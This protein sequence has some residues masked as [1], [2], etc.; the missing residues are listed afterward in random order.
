MTPEERL[1]FDKMKEDIIRLSNFQ[2]EADKN[3]LFDGYKGVTDADI[4]R[5]ITIGMGGG[6]ASVL[7]YPDDLVDFRYNGKLVRIPVYYTS[8]F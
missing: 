4:D 2:P 6:S 8:R 7:D 3:I 5:T 1:E